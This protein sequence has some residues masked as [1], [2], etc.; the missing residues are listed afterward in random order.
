MAPRRPAACQLWR[1]VHV[2]DGYFQVLNVAS[3][4][5]LTTRHHGGGPPRLT[6]AEPDPTTPAAQW[7]L[8]PLDDGDYHLT[9]RDGWTAQT[10]PAPHDDPR[11]F[12]LLLP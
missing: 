2:D 6:V 11:R 5:Q 10:N 12:Q 3:G 9:N 1:F 8:T 7:R 4:R